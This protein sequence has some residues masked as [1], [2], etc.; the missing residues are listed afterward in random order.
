MGRGTGGVRMPRKSEG[1]PSR[2][3]PPNGNQGERGQQKE[4]FQA[5]QV[6]TPCVICGYCNKPNHT[7]A[8][9][10]RKQGKCLICGS[11]EHQISS[12]F[13]ASMEGENTQQ[14]ARSASKQS[15]AEGGRQKVPTRVYALDNQQISNPTEVVECTIPVFHRLAR[16]LIDFRATYSFV[17]PNFMKGVDVKCDFLPFDLKVKTPTGNQCLIA[18]KVYRNCEIWVGERRLLADLMSLAIK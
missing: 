10:W 8:E 6:V 17:D 18:N 15:S 1:A 4:S 11:A 3:A 12:C 2:G 16:V 13:N 5:S 7:E 14:L 9:C